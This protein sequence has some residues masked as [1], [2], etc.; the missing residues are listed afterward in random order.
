MRAS[1]CL[2][3]VVIAGVTGC[4]QLSG[5][6]IQPNPLN[7]ATSGSA[8]ASGTSCNLI[9]GRCDASAAVSPKPAPLCNPGGFCWENPLPQGNDLYRAWGRAKNDVWFVG[10]Y[11]TLLHWNGS[12]LTRAVSPTTEA[13]TGV[14]GS[15]AND[16]WA[17]GDF[18]TILRWNGTTWN[19]MSGGGGVHLRGVFG[20]SATNVWMVG[21]SGTL[22]RWSRASSRSGPH[23]FPKRVGRRQRRGTAG[24]Q[25]ART[26]TPGAAA[27]GGV[28]SC[29]A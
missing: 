29:L 15:A 14:W 13:L 19:Q 5:S 3:L 7:C 28:S 22:L 9:T 1:V 24:P 26:V 11:G 23:S 20:T 27:A 8:C 21:D 18:G 25:G 10:D 12:T 4:D 2:T 17:V 16:V 6:L